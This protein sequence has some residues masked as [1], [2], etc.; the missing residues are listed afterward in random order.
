[1]EAIHPPSLR[2][3]FTS[4]RASDHQG[5]AFHSSIPPFFPSTKSEKNFGGITF[6]TSNLGYFR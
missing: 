1:M 4:F 2:F 5:Q 3:L 6:L